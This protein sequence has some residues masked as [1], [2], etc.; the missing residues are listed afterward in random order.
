MNITAASYREDFVPIDEGCDCY[1]CKIFTRAYLR[2][3]FNAGELLA[4][5]LATIHNL[6]FMLRLM[7]DIRMAIGRQEL[8]AF[9]AE[10]EARWLRSPNRLSDTRSQL[11]SP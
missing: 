11:E 2:H 9:R 4:Y 10:F 5:R 3:L 7:R 1:T 6:A 8:A